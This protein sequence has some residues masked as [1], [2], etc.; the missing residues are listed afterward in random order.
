MQTIG[1]IGG[2]NMAEAIIK[3][4]VRTNGQNPP[5]IL[6]HEPNKSRCETLGREYR[7]HF[8]ESNGELAQK[9]EIILLAVKPQV[10]PTVLKEIAPHVDGKQLI[11]SIMAGVP[12]AAIENAFSGPVR[13]VRAMPNMPATIGEGVTALCAG[14]HTE[15]GDV[16]IAEELFS[17]IGTVLRVEEKQMDAVTGLSGS[18]PAYVY[19][20]I[21]ALADGGVFSGLPRG[22]ALQLAIQTVLGSAK[23][24]S[25]SALHPAILRD[26]VCSPGGTTIAGVK[27]LEEHGFR[28]AV[29][30]AVIRATQ[31]SKELGKA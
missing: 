30:D 11:L 5:N 25:V 22:T 14:S 8:C 18:G 29:M 17:G 9:S 26:Q 7:L 21:E 28:D 2:G 1:L 3:G 31:R 20:L 24:A 12:T 23:L 6:L 4:I 10:S 27:A 19:M 16:R 15:S 13:V